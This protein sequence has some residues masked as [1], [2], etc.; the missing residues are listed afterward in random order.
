MIAN[1]IIYLIMFSLNNSYHQIKIK[2]A[3]LI[4]ALI[5]FLR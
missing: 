2:G 4:F 1:H 3:V 5:S